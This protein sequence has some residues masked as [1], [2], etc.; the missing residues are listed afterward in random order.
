M[1][2]I[3]DMNSK[4]LGY[5]EF[6]LP[7]CDIVDTVT[8]YEVVHYTKVCNIHKYKKIIISGTPLMDDA[9]I[10]NIKEL[11]WI[12]TCNIPVLGICAGM[13]AIGLVFGSSLITCKE[14]GMTKIE[15]VK[16]NVLFSSDF[17]AYELHTYGITPSEDFEVLAKSEK[18]IQGIKHKKKEI[19]GILFH[20]E[21]RNKKIIRQFIC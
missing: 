17:A 13:Q 14:I 2:L 4:K 9:Y 16:D 12:K 15:T 11:E 19:Y 18:C 1:I 21:V 6:V 7:L 10:N 8:E 5:Y 20:P 3:V